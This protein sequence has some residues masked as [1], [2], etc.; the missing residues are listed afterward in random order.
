MLPYKEQDRENIAVFSLGSC[1]LWLPYANETPAALLGYAR[2]DCI[3]S[4]GDP[5]QRWAFQ[6]A[7]RR[8]LGSDNDHMGAE[9]RTAPF[10]G[11][12][13]V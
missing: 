1:S 10:H 7:Q 8:P 3:P 5:R 13:Y 6:L 2:E 12:R 11:L 9:D 4:D